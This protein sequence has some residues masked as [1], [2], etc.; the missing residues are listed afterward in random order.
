MYRYFTSTGSLSIYH[1]FLVAI[2]G[3]PVNFVQY[4]YLIQYLCSSAS[5]NVVV[6]KYM[7]LKESDGL[8]TEKINT[9]I[10]IHSMKEPD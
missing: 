7:L 4:L 5:A 8:E 1:E 3:C 2:Y 6:S 9:L 10:W